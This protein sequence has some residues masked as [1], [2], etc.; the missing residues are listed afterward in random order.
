MTLTRSWRVVGR[1]Y[2]QA[3][4]LNKTCTHVLEYLVRT[5]KKEMELWARPPVMT[6][7]PSQA[8]HTCS[9]RRLFQTGQTPEKHARMY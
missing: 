1:A 6:P 8:I 7:V 3:V 9:R 5:A 4:P 2:I